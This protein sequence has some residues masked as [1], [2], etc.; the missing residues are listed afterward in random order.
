M[1]GNKNR[2]Q[3][4]GVDMLN[5]VLFLLAWPNATLDEMVV[6]IYN[7]GG[8]LYSRPVLKP[9]NDGVATEYRQMKIETYCQVLG[10]RE[11][12]LRPKGDKVVK[13]RRQMRLEM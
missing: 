8:D 7:E 2:S 1:T 12:V 5:L 11:N 10:E 9:E 13:M 6:H 3:I 4:V